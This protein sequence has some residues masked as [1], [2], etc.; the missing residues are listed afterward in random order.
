MVPRALG[1]PGTWLHVWVTVTLPTT[2]QNC[3]KHGVFFLKET[4]PRLA[5]S[6]RLSQEE[7]K[8]NKH[9]HEQIREFHGSQCPTQRVSL[10][11][12][13]KTKR[14]VRRT[15]SSSSVQQQQARETPPP[16]GI[17]APDLKTHLEEARNDADPGEVVQDGDAVGVRAQ[18][19]LPKR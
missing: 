14:A 17:K 11:F 16:H 8:R 6:G 19:A 2:H 5:R 12:G 15:D 3:F 13:V 18:S 9:T 1:A 4:E 10:F 7:G